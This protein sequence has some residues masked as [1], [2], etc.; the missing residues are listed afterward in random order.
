MLYATLAV[1]L[2]DGL[3]DF[4]KHTGTAIFGLISTFILGIFLT[5]GMLKYQSELI[6][7]IK[8][9]SP[10]DDSIND[11][12]L[13]RAAAMTTAMVKGQFIIAT[14]Q[15]ILSAFSLWLIGVEYFWF[16]ATILTFLSFIPLGAG[17]IT[18]PIGIVV[19]LTGNFAQGLFVIFYHILVVSNVDN[20]LRP[21]L[22]PKA[23]R[24]SSALLLLAVFSGLAVFGATGVVYGPV[25]MILLISALEIYAQY[26]QGR[27]RPK[28][29]V[30]K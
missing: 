10:F 29:L 2:L 17:I 26:N 23:A 12:Y 1:K 9:L 21:K 25:I 4:I 30:A 13:A 27:D 20:L 8:K 3:V 28:L 19:A 15:G 24:M 5:I 18:I 7:F 6:D 14:I 16:F 11:L 22:V